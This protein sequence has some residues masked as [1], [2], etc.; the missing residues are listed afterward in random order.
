MPS[1]IYNKLISAWHGTYYKNLESIIKYGL[2]LPKSKLENGSISL[3][4]KIIPK[5]K[6]YGINNWEM[7]IFLLLVFGVLLDIQTKFLPIIIL[8]QLERYYYLIDVMIKSNTYTEHEKKALDDIYE[9]YCGNVDEMDKNN[10]KMYRIT[11]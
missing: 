6:V 1:K 7:T 5:N 4:P 11:S 8:T 3:L 2:K 9:V 10:F